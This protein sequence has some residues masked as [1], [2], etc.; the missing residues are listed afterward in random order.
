[1]K[2]IIA[3]ISLILFVSGCGPE[4]F[5]VD[6][7]DDVK[8]LSILV[9]PPDNQ[10]PQ[11]GVEEVLYPLIIRGLGEKGYYVYSPEYV[12]EVFNRNKFDN[13]GR[14]HG[15]PPKKLAAVFGSDAILYVSVE[16]W[17]SKYMVLGNM[18]CTQFFVRLVD[19]KT[20]DELFNMRF[21]H[22]YDTA[23]GQSSLIGKLVASIVTKI[24]EKAYYEPASRM[25]FMNIMCRLPEGP[26]NEE[27]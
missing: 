5:L 21:K 12:I 2:R 11:E 22:Q 1:M 10:T 25:N 6:K 23:S 3:I 24:G 13:A 15:I 19:S 4:F 8:P 18:I 7:Y 9:L 26:K 14:I 16:E 27:W 20:G 17:A